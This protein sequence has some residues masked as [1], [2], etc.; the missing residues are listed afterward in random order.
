MA[1][2]N[3]SGLNLLVYAFHGTSHTNAMKIVSQK[4]FEVKNRKNHWLGTG[5]YFFRDDPEQAMSWAKIKNE[6]KNCAVI[7]ADLSLNSDY[8]L[9]LDSRDGIEYFQ[10]FISIIDEKTKGIKF[11]HK[12]NEDSHNVLMNFYCNFLTDEIKAIQRTF[13]TTSKR[14]NNLKRLKKVNM[15]LNGVQLC[16]RDQSIIDFDKISLNKLSYGNNENREKIN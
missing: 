5:V 7:K 10:K 9:N 11:K 12:N 14:L 4:K 16:I 8:F 13:K 6:E 2:F 3:R 15:H 1:D